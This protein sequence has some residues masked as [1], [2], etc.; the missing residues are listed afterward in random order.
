MMSDTIKNR[1]RQTPYQLV[2][3]NL[4]KVELKFL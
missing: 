4:V 2:G 3:D 1:G